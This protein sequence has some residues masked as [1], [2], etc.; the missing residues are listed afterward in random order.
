M[1][2]IDEINA[3]EQKSLYEFGADGKITGGEFA[4][5]TIDLTDLRKKSQEAYSAAQ[6]ENPIAARLFGTQKYVDPYANGGKVQG[7]KFGSDGNLYGV[8]GS[9]EV[10]ATD[11][12]GTPITTT[13][14]LTAPIKGWEFDT[15]TLQQS[16]YY[17]PP[18]Q[19]NAL[20]IPEGITY[21]DAALEKDAAS[22]LIRVSDPTTGYTAGWA[23]QKTQAP[24]SE[25]YADSLNGRAGASRLAY[26]GVDPRLYAPATDETVKR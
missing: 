22:Y 14:Y 8:L 21:Y 18:G 13:E 3:L 9:N 15:S 7:L 26:G 25:V 23:R 20:G 2:R 24:Q 5:M 6:T 12:D 1:A 11:V 19:K 16:P 10:T 4:G 17:K